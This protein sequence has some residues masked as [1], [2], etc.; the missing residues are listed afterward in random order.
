VWPAT[1]LLD[2]Y[3]EPA[4]CAAIRPLP[5]LLLVVSQGPQLSS[6]A[7]PA[8]AACFRMLPCSSHWVL[9]SRGAPLAEGPAL[10]IVKAAPDDA[11]LDP[12]RQMGIKAVGVGRAKGT[13]ISESSLRRSLATRTYFLRL[14]K[15]GPRRLVLC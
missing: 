4:A 2:A 15:L 5:P 13:D 14:T 1:T 7:Q 9:A 8:R 12:A 3:S 11:L 10:R 6:L